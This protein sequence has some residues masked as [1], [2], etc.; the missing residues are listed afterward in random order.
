MLGNRSTR[1]WFGL[2]AF[3]AGCGI[4]AP[5]APTFETTVTIP[6][7]EQRITIAEVIEDIDD[8]EVGEDDIRLTLSGDIDA[9]SLD[10]ELTVSVSGTSI[11]SEVGPITLQDDLEADVAFTFGELAPGGTIRGQLPRAA[12]RLH[13]ARA[14]G[15]GARR[16]VA[17][18]LLGGNARAHGDQRVAG[19]SGWLV[20]PRRQLPH[21]RR[22][23]VGDSPRLDA[24]GRDRHRRVG[25]RVSGPRGA[26]DVE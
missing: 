18:H 24:V 6:I 3:L 19:R 21:S 25:D 16:H 14:A 1:A 8:I 26:F 10:D 4:E 15:V 23:L 13:P 11:S 12:L 22:G 20:P 2:A 17:G 9:V 7:S 5:E